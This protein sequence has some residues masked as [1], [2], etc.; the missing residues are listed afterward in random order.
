MESYAVF[1]NPIAHSKSPAIHQLFA[2]QLH[3]A[4]PY[5]RILAPRDEF[6]STL[7]AFFNEG[8]RGA[9]VTVPFKEEAFARADE[10]TE[11]A[12]LAGAVNTLKR[13]EDGRLLGDNTDGIG[14]LSDLERLGFI[15]PG[16][17]V[18]LIGAGG[19]SRGVLLPLLSL[20]CAVTIVNRTSSRAHEL[21]A[22]FSHTGSIRALEMDALAEH[23]FDL[24]INATSS[25][26]GG[27][28]PAIPASLINTHVHCYD[29]FYQ[30]GSTPFLTWCQQHGA[31][32]CADGLGMLVAQAAHAVL[33]WHGVLPDITPVIQTLHKELNP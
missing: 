25:G 18:L 26:I 6:I 30:Q 10:L 19:A 31:K 9:N 14:L 2:Q 27:E 8:G 5:G 23:E 29:M 1:G 20:D 16:F 22:L 13:L 21:A 4:H 7:N 3:I 17:R 28:V 32:Q 12:A 24:I 11:R 33:L 15:K